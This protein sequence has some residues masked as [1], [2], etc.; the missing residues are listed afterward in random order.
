MN[1]F[2]NLDLLVTWQ[3]MTWSHLCCFTSRTLWISA[4]TLVISKETKMISTLN[5][6][7]LCYIFMLTVHQITC[8]VN[9]VTY[10][11]E[12]TV[13]M[14]IFRPKVQ[15]PESVYWQCWQI[16]RGLWGW[17]WLKWQW[18]KLVAWLGMVQDWVGHIFLVRVE[19]QSKRCVV[20]TM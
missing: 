7:Y 4:I 16:L 20:S 14:N 5:Q 10:S 17:R 12:P 13:V 18:H 8:E 15:T 6:D 3:T 1:L 9:R 19:G 11:N 2:W